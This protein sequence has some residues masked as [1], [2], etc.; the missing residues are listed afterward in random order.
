MSE[1]MSL[2]QIFWAAAAVFFL[3]AEFVTPSA[4]IALWFVAGSV[5]AL[6][7]SLVSHALW[8]QALVFLAV[9]ITALLTLRPVIMRCVR[10]DFIPTNADRVLGKTGRVTVAIR[11]DEVGRVQVEGLGWAARSE[12]PLEEGT[13]CVV[14]SMTG[15]TLTVRPAVTEQPAGK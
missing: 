15:A 11:P 2:Q 7:V 5:A 1:I 12:V 8:L 13:L 9:S 10:K 4:L 14:E 6:L 3:V